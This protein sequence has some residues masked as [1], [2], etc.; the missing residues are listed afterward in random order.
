MENRP[1]PPVSLAFLSACQIVTPRADRRGWVAL[2]ELP[3]W[4]LRYVSSV[5]DWAE[6]KRSAPSADFWLSQA[7]LEFLQRNPQGM[8]T[9][10][11]LLREAASAITVGCCVQTFRLRL[12]RQLPERRPQGQPASFRRRVTGKL[13]LRVSV[14][15]QMLTSGGHGSFGFGALSAAVL[16]RLLDALA[17]Q[18]T[19]GAGGVSAVVIKDHFPADAGV[20]DRLR[21]RGFEP[22]HADPVMELD[23]RDHTSPAEYL[24]ALTSK[25]R[26]RYRR[27]RAKAE[28]IT[29][30]RLAPDEV[31]RRIDRI[32]ALHRAT[33][34]GADVNFVELD[35]PYFVWLSERAAIHGYFDGER[36]IGFTTA[37]Q[38][39]N[40]YHAHYLGLEEAYNHSH[41]LY[42][43]MLFDLLED[44]LR[45]SA[46]VLDYGRTALEIKSSVGARP[47]STALLVTTR[48]AW[49]NRLLPS[50]LSFFHTPTHWTERSPF[51]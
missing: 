48:Y 11:L 29:R 26:V 8:H 32:Y 39:G 35:R 16:S 45:T 31:R 18:L 1:V 28:G 17:G 50:V 36:L 15:G 30:R 40:T 5:E 44:A 12:G 24:A 2:R 4:Q 34:R 23:L 13:S 19:S 42:H 7:F 25:Y 14:V 27:A 38:Q 49:L 33:R 21:A 51:R 37:L 10:I 9:D 6:W 46:T 43:N 22:L 41:H 47:R 3:G 20:G